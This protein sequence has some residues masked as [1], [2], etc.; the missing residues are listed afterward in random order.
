MVERSV[1]GL[2]ALTNQIYRR[3]PRSKISYMSLELRWHLLM[4]DHSRDPLAS[5]FLNPGFQQRTYMI[6]QTTQKLGTRRRRCISASGL[7][8]S[9]FKLVR[10]QAC[11]IVHATVANAKELKRFMNDVRGI[12]THDGFAKVVLKLACVVCS[13]ALCCIMLPAWAVAKPEETF[14]VTAN[15]AC[16]GPE[17]AAAFRFGLPR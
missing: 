5:W 13:S 16:V 6:A 15:S 14:G 17:H 12:E 3:A 10:I 2:H 1:E 11:S 8:H 9:C 4:E 7:K